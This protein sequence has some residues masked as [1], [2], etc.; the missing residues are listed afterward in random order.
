MDA[1]GK[2]SQERSAQWPAIMTVD[3]LA[4]LLRINRKTAYAMV[5]REGNP[6]RTSRRRHAARAP[7]HGAALAGRGHG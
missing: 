7:G 3:E 5:Q 1:D 4:G 2:A 6:R